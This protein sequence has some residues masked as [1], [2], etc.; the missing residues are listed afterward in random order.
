MVEGMSNSTMDFYFYEHF[1]YRKQNQVIFASGA[2]RAKGIL[3][4]IKSDVF[5]PI[6]VPSLRRSMY[7]ISFIDDFWGNKWI[8]FL[9]NK[10]K[11]CDKFT[12][13]KDLVENQA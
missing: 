7:Y 1:I 6:H 10:S 11:V 3:E 12:E 5:G 9:W 8:Y 13:F 4:L 2:T